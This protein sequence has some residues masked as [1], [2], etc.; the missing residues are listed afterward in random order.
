MAQPGGRKGGRD[1]PCPQWT[2]RQVGT[3]LTGNVPGPRGNGERRMCRGGGAREC[4]TL[5]GRQDL[6]VSE[7]EDGQESRTEEMACVG[8]EGTG[9]AAGC[10][11]ASW[12]V[13]HNLQSI[14]EE[15]GPALGVG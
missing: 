4:S 1:V 5:L 7:G 14:S 15:P 13:S 6:E 12:S 9:G 2:V 10:A 11:A 3:G 8:T